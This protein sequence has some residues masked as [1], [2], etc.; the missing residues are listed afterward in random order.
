MAA[1][2]Q[3]VHEVGVLHR[4]L[5]PG[6]IMLRADRSL[7]IIDFG[8]AQPLGLRV[9]SGEV[10]EIF[11]TPY[12]MSPEQ[13]HGREL[14]ERSDLYSLG[15]IFFEMLTG[16]K[17]YIDANAMNVLYMHANAP[18]PELPV[19]LQRHQPVLRRLLAKQPAQRFASA[20]ELLAYLQREA[21]A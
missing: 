10:G 9:A 12:Y 18:L 14:D 16:R 1:A 20:A 7:A 3:A 2:L 13:G 4:D 6:N 19:Q 11:G 17:P 8:L 15:V 5:K 21:V